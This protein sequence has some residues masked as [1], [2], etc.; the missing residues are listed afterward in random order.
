MVYCIRME[1]AF[2]ASITLKRET[3]YNVSITCPPLLNHPNRLVCACAWE[4]IAHGLYQR[5]CSLMVRSSTYPPPHKDTVKLDHLGA[6]RWQEAVP[7]AVSCGGEKDMAPEYPRFGCPGVRAQS[8]YEEG[9]NQGNPPVPIS[10]SFAG[11]CF[12]GDPSGR[13]IADGFLPS[14][15]SGMGGRDRV[16]PARFVV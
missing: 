3:R 16:T 12:G 7:A 5:Y 9:G 8:T 10:V 13:R 14:F 11:F 4:L 2:S 6:A 1:C 15:P